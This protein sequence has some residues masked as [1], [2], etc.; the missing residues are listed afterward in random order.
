MPLTPYLQG[1]IASW[2]EDWVCFLGCMVGFAITVRVTRHTSSL[3][4][5]SVGNQGVLNWVYVFVNPMRESIEFRVFVGL[6]SEWWC[7]VDRLLFVS[8]C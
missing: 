5:K 2:T 1:G 3:I 7:R 8:P 4:T 6:W